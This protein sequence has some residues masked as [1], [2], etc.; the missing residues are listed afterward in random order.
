MS[1]TGNDG[2]QNMFVYQPIFSKL[3]LKKDKDTSYIL[4]FKSQKVYRSALSPQHLAFLHNMN[5]SG[6]RIGIKLN[7]NPLVKEQN[8]YSTKIV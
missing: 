7:K 4:I 6:Q 3:H 5:L 2:V 8:K 1:F